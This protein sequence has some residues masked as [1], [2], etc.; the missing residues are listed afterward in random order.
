MI[1]NKKIVC[2]IPIKHNSERVIG[3][4]LRLLGGKPLYRHILDKVMAI[5]LFDDVYVDTDSEEIISYC[6]NNNIKTVSRIPELLEDSATGNDLFNHWIDIKPD[7]DLYYQ[8]H[9]TSPFMSMKSIEDC[10][11]ILTN[12]QFD[13][14][15]SAVE[16][17]SWYWFNDKRVN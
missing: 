17:K 5:D 14:I 10:V 8:V 6:R 11:K 7:Y 1:N 4:N 3:K 2:F 13:S 16:E 15:F 12:N 9:V